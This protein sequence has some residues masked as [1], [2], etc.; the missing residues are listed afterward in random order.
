MSKKFG[1]VSYETGDGIIEIIIRNSNGSKEEIYKANHKDKKTH[2]MIGRLLKDKWDIDLSPS[3]LKDK[4][5]FE[6]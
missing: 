5:M 2:A 3:T 6:Y 1:K 4:T